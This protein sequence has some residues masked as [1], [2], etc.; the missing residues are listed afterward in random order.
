MPKMSFYNKD[1]NNSTL[2]S[3]S[4]ALANRDKSVIN[5]GTITHPQ[6]NNKQDNILGGAGELATGGL[7][8]GKALVDIFGKGGES[9]FYNGEAELG[10]WLPNTGIFGEAIQKYIKDTPDY[11]A[12]GN[13]INGTA[14]SGSAVGDAIGAEVGGSMSP[15]GWLS[16][17]QGVFNGLNQGF[18]HEGKDILG[19]F[20]NGVQG[21]F[22]VNENDS[23][24]MQGINGTLDGAMK[25]TMIFPGVGTVIGGL[26]GLGSSFLDDI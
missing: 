25:G 12:I 9:G 13:A 20:G 5:T 26:L 18:N 16:L 22:G 17:G 1:R 24:V 7:K 21:F 14:G 19:G 8:F 4:Q 10:G 6:E 3:L 2:Q 15:M 23:D 11:G